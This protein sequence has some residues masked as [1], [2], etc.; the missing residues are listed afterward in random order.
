MTIFVVPTAGVK[1]KDAFAHVFS[2]PSQFEKVWSYANALLAPD[3]HI[4]HMLLQNHYCLKLFPGVL[5]LTNR[6]A[7]FVTR[8]VLSTTFEDFYW[9]MFKDVH[10]EERWSGSVLRFTTVNNQVY[11]ICNLPQH[12]ARDAFGF[13]QRIEEPAF[14]F[15]RW[16]RLEEE[17]AAARGVPL[18]ADTIFR[19]SDS[20]L[21]T[22]VSNTE[23]S[24]GLLK[25]LR[26]SGAIDENEYQQRLHALV[27]KI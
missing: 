17:R 16:Q 6:R 13:V 4:E 26:D 11:Q 18:P 10:M 23:E 19:P 15:R 8:G 2:S 7:I 3:E 1:P 14:E 24:I 12:T 20:T 21:T 22:A 25:R 27:D 5:V 9:R